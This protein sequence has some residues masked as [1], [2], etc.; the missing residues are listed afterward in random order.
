[1]I[2]AASHIL[3][4]LLLLLRVSWICHLFLCLSLRCICS[5]VHCKNSANCCGRQLHLSLWVFMLCVTHNMVH[6]SNVQQATRDCCCPSCCHCCC[7]C[8]CCC[9]CH[10]TACISVFLFGASCIVLHDL[11]SWEAW[12]GSECWIRVCVKGQRREGGREAGRKAAAGG[13]CRG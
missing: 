4:L 11:W 6:D 7:G 3:L 8:I 2:P 1:M 9:V 13:G 5:S 10:L 12:G